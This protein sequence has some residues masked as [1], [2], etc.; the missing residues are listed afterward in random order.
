MPILYPM[1]EKSVSMRAPVCSHLIYA[2]SSSLSCSIQVVRSQPNSHTASPGTT[3]PPRI[4]ITWPGHCACAR[5][6]T[7][8]PRPPPPSSR[9]SHIQ[10]LYK[11]RGRAPVRALPPPPPPSLL[12]LQLLRI[13]ASLSRARAS[14]P[15]FLLSAAWKKKAVPPVS[16]SL[17]RAPLREVVPASVSP[18]ETPAEETGETGGRG[19]RLR[20]GRK[21]REGGRKE[22]GEDGGGL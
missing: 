12:L 19:R 7:P 21:V 2:A 6:P 17:R 1:T 11:T 14:L 8:Q 10:L 16:V 13:R 5:H 20:P 18:S 22:P 9:H 3:P 15:T 4:S